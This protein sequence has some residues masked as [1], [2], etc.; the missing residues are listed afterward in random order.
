MVADLPVTSA[1]CWP[2]MVDEA[3]AGTTAEVGAADADEN[4]SGD[5]AVAIAKDAAS[6]SATSETSAFAIRFPTGLRGG[7]VLPDRL[8]TVLAALRSLRCASARLRAAR[9]DRLVD[10]SLR[11]LRL[12]GEVPR[13]SWS[14]GSKF[15][16][17]APSSTRIA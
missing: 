17:S 10:G 8:A 7:R 9:R 5:P 14:N 13:A 12:T 16:N 1:M 15:D 4:R 6:E 3:L 11:S 2:L